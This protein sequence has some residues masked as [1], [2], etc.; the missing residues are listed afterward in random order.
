MPIYDGSAQTRLREKLDY[1]LWLLEFVSQSQERLAGGSNLSTITLTNRQPGA[2]EAITVTDFLGAGESM[3]IVDATTPLTFT[4]SYKILDMIFE[5]ILEENR[6]DGRIMQV[7]WRFYEKIETIRKGKTQLMLPPLFLSQ[8]YVEKYLFALYANLLKFRNEI[9]HKHRFSVSGG[10]L[11]IDAFEDGQSHTVEL[12][13]EE[14]GAF[15][16]IVVASANILLGDLS[17]GLREDSLFK[18]NLDRIE[19]LHL[20]G[21]FGQRK[22]L[23]VDVVLKVNEQGGLFAADLKFVRETLSRIYPDSNVRFNLKIVGLVKDQPSIRWFFPVNFV[24][25]D[26]VLELRPDAYEEHR[27][28]V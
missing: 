22:P 13:P 15:V 4:A 20:L 2:N 19:K 14:L 11:R 28:A 24:P 12:D 23:L 10:K 8:R 27:T 16:R 18:W 3:K 5:W 21:R 26:D 6:N 17:L 1:E 9:V 7:P 25:R